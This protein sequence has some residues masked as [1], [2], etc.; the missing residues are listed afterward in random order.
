MIE[1]VLHPVNLMREYRQM[2]DNKGATRV[3]GMQVEEL[4][5]YLQIHRKRIKE[6]IRTGRYLPQAIRGV[7]IPK[8]N[9]KK[10][11]LGVPTAIDRLLQQATGQILCNCYDMDFEDN[12]Y[13][14]RPNRTVLNRQFCA[15]WITLTVV[16]P[17][18]LR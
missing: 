10:R 15:H 13:G 3:D 11:L 7:E 8:S 12:S 6:S 17:K 14:F 16:I 9:G 4:Y 5:G 2:V 1:K 18:L